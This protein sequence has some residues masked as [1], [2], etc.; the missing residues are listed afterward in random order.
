MLLRLPQRLAQLKRS[1][2]F[3]K[4]SVVGSWC[5]TPKCQAPLEKML[6]Q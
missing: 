3:Q 4:A 1:V 5:S 2:M 6:S